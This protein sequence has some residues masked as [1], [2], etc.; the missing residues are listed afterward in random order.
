MRPTGD[1][2]WSR[3]PG[4]DRDEPDRRSTSR[5]VPARELFQQAI[6]LDPAFPRAHAYLALIWAVLPDYDD[7]PLS[8][9]PAVLASLIER[10]RFNAGFVEE[11]A[12]SYQ[13]GLELDPRS[14]IIHQNRAILLSVHLQDIS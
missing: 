10:G 5:A 9:S 13:N 1:R 6:A 11:A 7:H 14:R 12:A 4:P 2:G 8:E 3:V